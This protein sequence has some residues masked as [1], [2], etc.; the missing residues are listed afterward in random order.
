MHSPV[1][2]FGDWSLSTTGLSVVPQLGLSMRMV[3]AV[4]SWPSTRNFAKSASLIASKSP[5]VSLK[6]TAMD[7][8]STVSVFL[9][10]S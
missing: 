7:E 8:R 9:S 6:V 2:S 3:A 10:A 4:T 1:T 5:S